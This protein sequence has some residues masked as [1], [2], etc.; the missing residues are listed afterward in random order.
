MKRLVLTALFCLC[1]LPGQAGAQQPPSH[2]PNKPDSSLIE[3]PG[4]KEFGRELR[5]SSRELATASKDVARQLP[6][7]FGYNLSS[8]ANGWVWALCLSLVFVGLAIGFL[9]IVQIVGMLLAR[10]E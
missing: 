7:D 9:G 6:V 4:L 8:T 1:L 10:K 5:E 2:N 3:I